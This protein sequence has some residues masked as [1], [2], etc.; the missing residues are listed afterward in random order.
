MNTNMEYIFEQAKNAIEMKY[1]SKLP[2]VDQIFAEAEFIRKIYKDY[3]PVSEDE[4]KS[5]KKRLP[6][7]ILH[8][9]GYADTLRGRDSKHQSWYFL[10]E[11][12]DFFWNRYKKYLS[13]KWSQEVVD[14]LHSTTNNILDDLGDPRQEQPF[15]RRG[16]LLGDV[17]SGKTATYT[18]V[19]NKAADAGYK[20]IIIL[21]GMMETLEFRRKNVLMQN[22]L[23]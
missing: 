6:E 7:N 17:Q 15:Q 20:V 3:Y 10:I 9:I 23:V 1:K 14:R 22:L 21:A 11:N 19:C 12:E 18:A 8:S 5:I 2:T 4:F 13:K 16:L